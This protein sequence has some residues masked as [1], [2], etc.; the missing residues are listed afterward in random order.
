MGAINRKIDTKIIGRRVLESLGCENSSMLETTSR[1]KDD[2]IYISASMHEDRD[3]ADGSIA[4]LF[5]DSL[6]HLGANEE[7]GLEIIE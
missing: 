2:D 6:Y 5:G 3:D 4:A 1:R 7:D